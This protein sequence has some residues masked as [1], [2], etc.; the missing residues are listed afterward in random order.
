MPRVAV[1]IDWQNAYKS[2]RTAFALEGMPNERG[3]FSPY[4]LG[5]ILAAGNGR[6]ATGE[7]V[8]VEIHRGLPSNERDSVGYAANRRQSAAWMNENRAIVIPRPRPLRYSPYDAYAAPEEK[9]ID[10]Q[11]ALSIVESVLLGHC[12][13]AVLFSFDTDLL[14]AV[15]T[16]CRLKG[17]KHIETASWES[18]DF[19]KRLRPTRGVHHHRLSGAV[20]QRV[21]T[22][23]NYAYQGLRA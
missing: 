22:P 5:L 12:D 7:L 20:F 11:L 9:G 3:N 14:P 8:R 13:V 17:A 1:F 4:N 16:T 21:E 15:E 23:V 18:H 10:V 6:G 19:R 2:A